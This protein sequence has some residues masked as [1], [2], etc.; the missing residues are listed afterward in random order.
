MTRGRIELPSGAV[1]LLV[2][3]TLACGAEHGYG[4]VRHVKAQSREAL[5]IEEGSLY[6]ALHRV[7]RRGWVEAEW[8]RSKTGRKAKF[9]RLTDDGRKRLRAQRRDW[10]RMTEAVGRVLSP[11]GAR[12]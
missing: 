5:A 12:A 10:E 11:R 3:R 8:G 2:L 7:E 6:P 9:Y 4:I 1:E